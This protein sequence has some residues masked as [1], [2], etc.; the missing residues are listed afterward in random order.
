MFPISFP[1]R[2]VLKSA[3]SEAAESLLHIIYVKANIADSVLISLLNC[4]FSSV[5]YFGQVG[6]MEPFPFL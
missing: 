6:R 3:T 2:K 4:S 1:F 5:N